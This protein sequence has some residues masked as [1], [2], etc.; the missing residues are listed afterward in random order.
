MVLMVSQRKI[1][2]VQDFEIEIVDDT[3]IRPKAAHGL[4]GLQVGGGSHNLSYTIRTI[5]GANN[6]EEM[7]YGQAGSMLMY[8][9]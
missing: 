4:A 6:N 2:E 9:Q 7:T 3:R 5:Y 8:F 1:S